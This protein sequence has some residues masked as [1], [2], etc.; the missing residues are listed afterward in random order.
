MA[1]IITE[2]D[3]GA[4][5]ASAAPADLAAAI[6]EVLERVDREGGAWRRRIAASAGAVQL[7]AGR[8]RL[9]LA[10][11]LARSLGRA[12]ERRRV[13]VPVDVGRAA[14]ARIEPDP[15]AAQLVDEPL[16][17]RIGCAADPTRYGV[18]RRPARQAAPPSRRRCR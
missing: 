17:R 6:R 9:S 8:D 16:A 13:Y 3:L 18:E 15:V 7:A 14:R 12:R 5:A 4:V 1:G 11:A 2:Y 10:R